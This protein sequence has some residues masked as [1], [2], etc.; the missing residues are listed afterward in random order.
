MTVDKLIYDSLYKE[1]RDVESYIYKM[2][3]PGM[4]TVD[5]TPLSIHK[6]LSVFVAPQ[7]HNGYW[8][9]F[10]DIEYINDSGTYTHKRD[11]F[12]SINIGGE[13]YE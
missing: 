13:C 12:D 1:S 4:L 9:L 7:Y 3:L 5:G 2:L 6:L 10:M 11:I 8:S